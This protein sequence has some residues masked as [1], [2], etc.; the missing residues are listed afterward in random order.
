MSDR[1][2]HDILEATGTTTVAPADESAAQR[3]AAMAIEVRAGAKMS[4]GG[5][6]IMVGVLAFVRWRFAALVDPPWLLDAWLVWMIGAVGY[7]AVAMAIF[8]LRRP[9]DWETVTRWTRPGRHVQTLL[10]VGIAACPWVLLP[11][12]DLPLQYITT[13]LYVWYVAT[14]VMTSNTGVPMPAREV[15]LLTASNVAFALW[16]GGP[17]SWALAAFVG[18][19]GLTLLGFRQQ[20]RQSAQTAVAAQVASERAEA[21]TQIALARTMAERDGKTRFIAAASHDL[22]QP[23]YAAGLFFD[24]ALAL[25]EGTQRDAAIGGV[26]AAFSSTQALLGAMLDHLRLEHGAVSARLSPVRLGDAI[27]RIAQEYDAPAHA[28]GMKIRW[29]RSGIAV[30]ADPDLLHRTLGNLVTNAIRHSRGEHVL[31]AA[32]RRGD[33]A[34]L[35]IVDDGNGVDPDDAPRLFEDFAQGAKADSA[36][37]GIGLA[38]VRRLVALMAGEVAHE[39]RWRAGAAF[40]VRLPLAPVTTA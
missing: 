34:E 33:R 14:I 18:L 12:A 32:R 19:I 1:S 15:V 10:N 20:V 2:A 39:P 37:F 22:Q 36:G 16:K 27:G 24:R 6:A 9:D 40:I 23:L 35:W 3:L 38:S 21:L 8:H 11:G 7:W 31:L 5:M 29:V 30:I 17:Y 25:P 4:F 26:R 28:A 13:L